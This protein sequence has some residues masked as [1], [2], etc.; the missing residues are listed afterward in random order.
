VGQTIIWIKDRG[1][2]AVRPASSTTCP[3]STT[4]R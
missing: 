3:P 1:Y 4:C 2:S